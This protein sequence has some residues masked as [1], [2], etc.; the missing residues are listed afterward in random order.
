MPFLPIA[1]SKMMISSNCRVVLQFSLICISGVIFLLF[2]TKL[3][4]SGRYQRS[5]GK[6]WIDNTRI[7]DILFN[8]RCGDES[9]SISVVKTGE[10]LDM[11]YCT[12]DI[13]Q[14]P[15]PLSEYVESLL[16]FNFQ[17]IRRWHQSTHGNYSNTTATD[18]SSSSTRACWALQKP[19]GSVAELRTTDA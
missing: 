17:N 13:R 16:F 2:R 10:Q 4:Y 15:L 3:T 18:Y 1:I 9:H 11:L 6:Y 19:V 7:T 14:Y 8:I 12:F 5:K